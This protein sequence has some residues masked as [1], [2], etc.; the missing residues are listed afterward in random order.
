MDN[1]LQVHMYSSERSG[2]SEER[3]P[4]M[5]VSE[6]EIASAPKVFTF[7]SETDPEM[8]SDDDDLEDVLALPL[9]FP[10]QL[11]IEHPDGE[12]LV[13]HIPIHAIPFAAIPAE[14][15]PFVDGLDDDVDVPVIEVEHLDDDL[16]DGEVYDLAILELASPVV[17]VIDISSDTDLEFDEDSFESVTSLALLT[18]WLRARPTD[19]DDDAVSG[20]PSSPVHVS[21]P[22]HTPPHTLTQVSSLIRRIHELEDEVTPLHSIII[23][24]PPPSPLAH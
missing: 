8:I 20:A 22:T 6:D 4:M 12:R 7:D 11:I 14:D 19:D 9:P 13:E 1:I 24:T 2:L 16:G 5:I 15:W 21:K 10:D 3:E 18:A 23:P 17:F